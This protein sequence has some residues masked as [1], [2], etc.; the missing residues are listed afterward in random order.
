MKKIFLLVVA[1][2]AMLSSCKQE[3]TGAPQIYFKVTNP[4]TAIVGEQYEIPTPA[5][6]KVV[7]DDNVDGSSVADNLTYV[8]NIPVENAAGNIIIP[9]TIGNYSIKYSVKDQA[10]NE[11]EKELKVVVYNEATPYATWY[12]VTKSSNESIS[13][14]YVEYDNV[15]VKLEQDAH[16]NMRLIFPKLS[17]IEGLTIYGD[18][19]QGDNDTTLMVNIPSQ[20]IPV[21]TFDTSGAPVDTFLYVIRN[22]SAGSSYFMDLDH[23]KIRLKYDIN[24]FSKATFSNSDYTTQSVPDYGEYWKE[25]AQDQCVEIYTKM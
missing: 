4:D 16:I 10:G 23:Y 20:E 19:V 5:N 11:S 9:S 15:F 13:S 22:T 2:A 21:V 17:N 1:A 14:D 12:R 6:N 8:H 7:V 24:K 3:D 18:L 25:E